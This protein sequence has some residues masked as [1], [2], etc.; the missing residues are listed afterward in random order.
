MSLAVKFP[1]QPN[2]IIDDEFFFF[3]KSRTASGSKQTLD[4]HK[5]ITLRESIQTGDYIRIDIP[6]IPENHPKRA[7]LQ[8]SNY[9][10][11]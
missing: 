9:L 4:L 8:L 7:I 10:K 1:N 2:H 5:W 6:P 3:Q 11:I